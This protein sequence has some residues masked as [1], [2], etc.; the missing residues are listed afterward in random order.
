LRVVVAFAVVVINVCT[1][2][3][4]V[5][6]HDIVSCVDIYVVVVITIC[7]VVVV[8]IVIVFD[9]GITP[10]YVDVVDAVLVFVVLVMLL[11]LSPYQQQHKH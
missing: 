1:N 8:V 10:C 11:L 9:D 7:C 6:A 2:V 5:D 3:V 4:G